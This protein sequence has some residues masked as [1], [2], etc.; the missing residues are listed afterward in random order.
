[1]ILF[2]FVKT[3][4]TPH[5]KDW[6]VDSLSALSREQGNDPFR[7]CQKKNKKGKSDRL[8]TSTTNSIL[9]LIRYYSNT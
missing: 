5:T 8:G 1:M 6:A 4:G 7:F 3:K 2:V 9:T